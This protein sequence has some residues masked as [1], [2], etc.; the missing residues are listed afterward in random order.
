[1]WHTIFTLF[2]GKGEEGQSKK[3]ICKKN[4]KE[5]KAGC[6]CSQAHTRKDRE[7]FFLYF[8]IL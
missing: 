4:G 5:E 6:W 8:V 7:E 1:V 3:I 2:K